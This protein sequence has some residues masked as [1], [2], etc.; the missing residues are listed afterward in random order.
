MN[1]ESFIRGVKNGLAVALGYYAVSVT[2]GIAASKAGL[3]IFQAGLASALSFTSTGEFAGF[4]LMAAAGSYIEMA[5]IQLVINARYILMSTAL[6]QKLAEG[7]TTVQRLILGMGVTDEIF[8]LSIAENGSL[9]PFY[10]M[11]ILS[12][13][14]PGWTLGTVT[15]AF[16]GSNLPPILVSALSVSLYGM[17]IA[18]FIPAAKKDRIVAAAV[19][20]SFIFSYI[21]NT[22]AVFD[23]ISSG[24]K[25]IILTVV[26]SAVFAV[27]FPVKEEQ[28]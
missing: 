28:E 5:V 23:F 13:A 12:V 24:T 15:G 1:R 22:M 4:N 3:N 9:N 25:I 26:I 6:S 10:T 8:G 18:A 14:V 2:I 7:T 11:G 20:I 21:F 17:F 27:L 19:I 16:L